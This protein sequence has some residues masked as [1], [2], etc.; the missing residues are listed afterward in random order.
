MKA[1]IPAL[2]LAACAPAY[3]Y[4]PREPIPQARLVDVVSISCRQTK[5][6]WAE[7][8]VRNTSAETLQFPRV[9]VDF[10]TGTGDGYLR[11]QQVPPGSLATFE[12]R[13]PLDATA[14]RVLAVQ[15]NTGRS[16]L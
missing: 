8:T 10:G 11:P 1:I 14:C 5:V 9:F 4:Q 7:G 6:T 12:A 13:G 3:E 16:I 15:D 2:L